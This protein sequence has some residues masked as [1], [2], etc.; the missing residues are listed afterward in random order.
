[1]AFFLLFRLALQ[2]LHQAEWKLG[3]RLAHHCFIHRRENCQTIVRERPFHYGRG[4]W[5]TFWKYNLALGLA[6]KNNLA[7]PVCWKCFFFALICCKIIIYRIDRGAETAVY[8]AWLLKKKIWPSILYEKKIWLQMV[9]EKNTA[10]T[11]AEN[12]NLL[13]KMSSSPPPI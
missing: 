1:M 13:K 9:C 8:Q 11:S 3:L 12:N 6:K 7:Q 4:G 10:L 5:K 2:L